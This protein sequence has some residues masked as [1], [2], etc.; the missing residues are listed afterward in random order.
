M[1]KI[2]IYYAYWTQNWGA[3][4]VPFVEKAR[5]LGFD[6]LEVDSVAHLPDAERNRLKDAT[7]RAGI[8]LTFSTALTP[9]TDIAGEDA[10]ARRRGIAFLQDQAR[11]LQEMGAKQLGGVLSG[12]WL[13]HMP[14]GQSDK[15]P[16]L[17]RSIESMQEV[18]KVAED[19]GVVLTVEVLNRFEQFLLNTAEEARQ[20]VERVGSPHCQ[21]MLDTFHMNIEEDS[22]GNAFRIAGDRLGHVHIGE[23]NRR[24]PGRGRV[25][26]CEVFDTLC[27]LGY[28][29]PIVMEPFV[30]A[31]GEVAR[32]IGVWRDLSD[33]LDLDAEAARGLRFVRE[34]LAR[35]EQRGRSEGVPG[36]AQLP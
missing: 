35:A 17:D 9:E 25:P 11:M 8:E 36:D 21:I 19:C 29:G 15:R 26:W 4:Y 24:V 5:S 22:L 6:I 1:N 34:Q 12:C 3:D 14:A 16:F 23:T 27:D 33:G 32:D 18:M 20:Y 28:Q 10:Q 30:M 13:G 7:R 31:G 2:G